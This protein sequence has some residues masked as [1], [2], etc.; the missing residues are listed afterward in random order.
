[1]R[2]FE[3]YLRYRELI[4]KHIMDFVP[5][6]DHKSVTLYESMKYSLTNGGKR[7]R[8]VLLLAACEFSGGDVKAALPYA[9]AIEYIHTYSL[10]H[11]D[12]PVMDDDPIRRGRPSNHV[13]YGDAM[14]LLAGDG[15]LTTAFE[16][17]S[18]DMLL[19]LDSPELLKRRVRAAF[20]I[21]KCAGCRGMVAGQV[22]DIEA[23]H[24]TVSSELLDYIHLNKTATL[25][26]ASV[27]A[28]AY[29]GGADSKILKAMEDYAENLGLAFQIADDILDVTGDE[30]EIGKMT[31]SDVNHE[32]PTHPL[33]HGLEQSKKR[34][35]ELT[36]NALD[37]IAPFYDNA[38]F[39]VNMAQS[40]AD[41]KR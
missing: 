31:G 18:K 32:K 9:C 25:I 17:M 15:L 30:K 35:K 8:P 1:L 28:G 10:I 29:L 26:I 39:F 2:E 21:A 24:K 33:F 23:E 22:A 7:V 38:E 41:R 27:K 19:Y 13:V 6:V 3:E 37:V 34:L 4:E 36:D 14:A 12:L 16:V 20:E 11:D 5:E 40:L